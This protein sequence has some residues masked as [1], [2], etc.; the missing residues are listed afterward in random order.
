MLARFTL[1]AIDAL[2]AQMISLRP[3]KR[4]PISRSEVPRRLGLT[5]LA[6]CSASA[7]ALT[8]SDAVKE[9]GRTTRCFDTFAGSRC[10]KIHPSLPTLLLGQTSA[11]MRIPHL[12]ANTIQGSVHDSGKT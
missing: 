8:R 6:N 7:A 9:F 5:S 10:N 1:G 11:K 12:R 4:A 3:K 2:L